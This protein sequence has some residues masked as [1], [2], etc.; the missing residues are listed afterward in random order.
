MNARRLKLH[1]DNPSSLSARLIIEFLKQKEIEIT[2]H[3]DYSQ[4]LAM[5][6]ISLFFNIKENLHGCSFHSEE[7]I[8]VVINIFFF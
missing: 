8:D 5:Q 7:E 3:S 6:D 4:D 2:E 1:H